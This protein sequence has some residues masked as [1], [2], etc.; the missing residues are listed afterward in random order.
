MYKVLVAQNDSRI[1]TVKT[2]AAGF[3]VPA[4][5]VLLVLRIVYNTSLISNFT[6]S[7]DSYGG[8]TGFW[9]DTVTSVLKYVLYDDKIAGPGVLHLLGAAI[10]VIYVSILIGALAIA[11]NRRIRNIESVNTLWFAALLSLIAFSISIQVALSRH[12]LYPIGRRCIYLVPIY[13]LMVLYFWPSLSSIVHRAARSTIN[14]LFFLCISV[15]ILHGVLCMNM[16]HNYDFLYDA[17]TKNVMRIIYDKTRNNLPAEGK[18][19]IGI[20]WLFEPATNYYIFRDKMFWID[21]TTRNG[22][23]GLYDFYYLLD[24]D[25]DII[26]KYDLQVIRRSDVSGSIF[27]IRKGL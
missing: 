24:T 8:R 25:K 21:F 4:A 26:N 27:A 9:A 10:F 7:I 22:P 18:Y 17:D 2:F 19:R 20:N 14:I 6:G 13:L 15:A 1:K 16:T 11:V 5:L 3:L 12:M 23:D